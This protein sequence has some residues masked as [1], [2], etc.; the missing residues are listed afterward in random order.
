MVPVDQPNQCRGTSIGPYLSR[1]TKGRFSPST[2]AKHDNSGSVIANVPQCT[3]DGVQRID[4]V[5]GA[6][7]IDDPKPPVRLGFDHHEWAAHSSLR[8]I[9]R[10]SPPST[11][12]WVNNS[13]LSA[14]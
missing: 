11:A 14:P 3:I 10:T 9:A 1:E 8:K 4:S 7:R 5:P 13:K 12:C 6:K 2:D